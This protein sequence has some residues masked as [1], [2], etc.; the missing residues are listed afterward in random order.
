MSIEIGK[1]GVMKWE[2]VTP[3]IPWS[4]AKAVVVA[5]R[6]LPDGTR[7]HM[8]P[9]RAPPGLVIAN[10]HVIGQDDVPKAEF[11]AQLSHLS[12]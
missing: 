7:Q 2:R 5:D 6:H 8:V 4:A 1:D 9:G 10:A 3:P 11:A 12:Q